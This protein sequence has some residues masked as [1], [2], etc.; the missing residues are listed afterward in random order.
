MSEILIFGNP[1]EWI[2]LGVAFLVTLTSIRM[3]VGGA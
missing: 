3:L 2:L 1:R